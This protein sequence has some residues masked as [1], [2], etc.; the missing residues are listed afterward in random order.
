MATM[1]N[2]PEPVAFRNLPWNKRI[3]LT[4]KTYIFKCTTYK[5]FVGNKMNPK[6]F[7]I[8]KFFMGCKEEDLWAIYDYLYSLSG[9][10]QQSM[11]EVFCKAEE[12]RKKLISLDN[13]KKIAELKVEQYQDYGLNDIM[14]W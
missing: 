7:A 14:N 3:D 9:K 4:T 8:R 1:T 12:H 10:F 13:K 11:T 2:L 6:Y 5:L